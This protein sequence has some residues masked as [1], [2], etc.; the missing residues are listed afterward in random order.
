MSLLSDHVVTF[1]L[2]EVVLGVSTKPYTGEAGTKMEGIES[3]KFSVMAKP[4]QKN[5]NGWDST[6]QKVG[7]ASLAKPLMGK[8]FPAQ[9]IISYTRETTSQTKEYDGKS[10][11]SDLEKLV[12][13][14]IQYLHPVVI[15]AAPI[16]K[17]TA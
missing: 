3:F 12:P 1:D 4:N 6:I 15:L 10:V 17:K 14:N 9:C 7:N 13:V 8:Q 5:W 2:K 16:E 11:S